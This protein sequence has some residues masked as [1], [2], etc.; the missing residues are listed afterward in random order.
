[1]LLAPALQLGARHLNPGFPA[2]AAGPLP[3]EPSEPSPQVFRL[4]LKKAS[5]TSV[6]TVPSLHR[7]K[8]NYSFRS[9]IFFSF[10]RPNSGKILKVTDSFFSLE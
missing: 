1:M 9:G 8:G 2:S 3:R 4:P 7:R 10:Y 6:F 5:H